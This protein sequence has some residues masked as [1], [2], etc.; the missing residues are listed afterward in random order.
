MFPVLH[1][2]TGSFDG[3]TG[4]KSRFRKIARFS[5]DSASKSKKDGGNRLPKRRI[6]QHI[7]A[8]DDTE[9]LSCHGISSDPRRAITPKDSDSPSYLRRVAGVSQNTK[10]REAKRTRL[11]IFRGTRERKTQR[12]F[13]AEN[14]VTQRVF[15]TIALFSERRRM[16]ICEKGSLH[17]LRFCVTHVF[18][19]FFPITPKK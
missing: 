12:P 10:S 8:G 4:A 1:H 3:I 18:W 14:V 2:C 19:S 7:P 6:P 16:S 11:E 13:H 5:H 9:Q 15:S 17:P